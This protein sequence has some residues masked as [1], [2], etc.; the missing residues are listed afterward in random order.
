MVQE[1]VSIGECLCASVC[2]FAGHIFVRVRMR[3]RSN[4]GLKVV[5]EMIVALKTDLHHTGHPCNMKH[6]LQN[7]YCLVLRC[8]D[9]QINL[10]GG[11]LCAAGLNF[12]FVRF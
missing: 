12:A 7:M 4:H 10:V 1:A 6:V 8:S 9:S 11:V 5:T 2:N 3:V